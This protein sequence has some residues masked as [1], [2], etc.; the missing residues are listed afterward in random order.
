MNF[1]LT[2]NGFIVIGPKL[3]NKRSFESTLRDDLDIS[4]ILPSS[5]TGYLEVTPTVKFY[6]VTMVEP[7]SFNS[8]IQ[9]YA[10][11]FYTF[12]ATSAVGTYNAVDKNISEVKNNLKGI[13]AE[14]RYKIE[15]AGVKTIIQGHE[16]SV[17]TN[18][19][20]RNMYVQQF[21]FMD[22]VATVNWKFPE[23]WLQISKA[24]MGAVITACVAHIRAAFDWEG[25]KSIEIDACTTLAELDAVVLTQV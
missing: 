19:D 24:E 20:S 13:V 6:P 1:V 2:N 15:N 4:F 10:G 17:L 9:Q 11:P 3:W 25:V 7:S 12:D 5:N 18:R 14:N 8:K 21:M 16:V 23:I 22:D